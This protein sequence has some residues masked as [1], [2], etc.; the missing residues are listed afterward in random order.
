VSAQLAACPG[1][2]ALFPDAAGP[3]HRYIGAD[4]GCWAIFS[5]LSAGQ[6]PDAAIVVASRVSG[7]PV[8]QRREGN[9]LSALL[10]DAYATQH[11]G[12]DS[13]QAVQSV[14]IHLLTLHGVLAMGQAPSQ[15]MWVRRR[16]LR[17]KGVF[18]L[19]KPPPVGR[20]LTVRHLFPGGG[21]DSPCSVDAYVTSVY[22]AWATEHRATIAEWYARFVTAD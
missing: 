5:A 7:T 8:H 13:V 10:G 4:P 22:D 15:A 14:G 1:C 21:V 17:K 20:A 2:G 6:E 3:T 19:L 9:A 18:S 12:D 16:T 11:H